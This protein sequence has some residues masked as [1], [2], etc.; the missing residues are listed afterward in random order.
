MKDF[1]F[2]TDFKE[3][4]DSVFKR[5]AL[6]FSSFGHLDTVYEEFYNENDENIGEA[7]KLNAFDVFYLHSD[8]VYKN[9]TKFDIDISKYKQKATYK[10]IKHIKWEQKLGKMAYIAYVDGVTHIL[11]KPTDKQFEYDKYS[12]V[13][14]TA[15]II[16]KG[17]SLESIGYD[18][19][20]RKIKG[21]ATALLE[22]FLLTHDPKYLSVLVITSEPNRSSNKMCKQY[23][24]L[25][26][27][28]EGF[29]ELPPPHNVCGAKYVYR[30]ID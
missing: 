20:S 25:G 15:N 7:V 9:Q 17:N 30:R 23:E 13:K 26:F 29:D 11:Q 21:R 12:D 16:I 2:F 6:S 19:E 8:T 28:F 27:D 24:R 22:W 4:I 10:G 18:D 5:K 3:F 14:T 1:L